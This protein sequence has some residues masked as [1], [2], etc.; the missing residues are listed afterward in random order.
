MTTLYQIIQSLNLVCNISNNVLRMKA[1]VFPY[2]YNL[3]IKSNHIKQIIV[4]TFAG[5]HVFDKP[6]NENLYCHLPKY[7]EIKFDN[8]EINKLKD[9]K[10]SHKPI[11]DKLMTNDSINLIMPY[12][13]SDDYSLFIKEDILIHNDLNNKTHNLT[14]IIPLKYNIILTDY[15]CN[16]KLEIIGGKFGKQYITNYYENTIYVS[17]RNKIILH[18]I[19][20]IEKEKLCLVL[21]ATVKKID[22]F[23]N[24]LFN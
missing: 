5:K 14:Q 18:T 3:F 22:Y 6:S 19:P 21:H 11:N 16:F 12:K 9:I 4:C 13:C 1:F 10:C 24:P 2:Q 8:F 7:F 17:T 15:I 23:M 20:N